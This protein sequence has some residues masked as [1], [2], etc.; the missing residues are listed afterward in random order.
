MIEWAGHFPKTCWIRKKKALDEW[1]LS[2]WK[3]RTGQL[4][5]TPP[6]VAPIFPSSPNHRGQSHLDS[7]WYDPYITVAGTSLKI[8][9]PCKKLNQNEIGI[10][11]GWRGSKYWKRRVD[12]PCFYDLCFVNSAENNKNWGEKKK[13]KKRRINENK[14][15][16]IMNHHLL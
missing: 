3:S 14:S 6:Y 8:K 13:E 16:D 4:C 12:T 1:Q 15:G 10:G 2:I 7:G 5:P 11:R 9:L